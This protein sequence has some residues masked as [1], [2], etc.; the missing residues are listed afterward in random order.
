MK[1]S[2]SRNSLGLKVQK[3]VPT[4]TSLLVM[5][6]GALV[7]VGWITDTTALKSIMPYW[8]TMKANTAIC[9]FLAGLSLWLRRRENSP[10]SR[11]LAGLIC[12]GIVTLIS[13]LTLAE[14]VGQANFGIDQWLI[15]AAP[16]HAGKSQ[17]GRM[18]CATALGFFLI[19]QAVLFLDWKPPGGRHFSAAL[20][21]LAGMIGLLPFAGYLYGVE[22]LYDFAPFASMAM[23]TALCLMSLASGILC[24]RVGRGPFQVLTSEG[25][26]GGLS[27]RLMPV[28]IGV[29]ILIG[30]FQLLGE[31]AGF[32]RSE[33]GLALF[34]ISNV[35]T[36]SILIWLT[37]IWLNRTDAVVRESERRYRELIESLPQLVWTCNANGLCDYLGPQWVAYTGVPEAGQLG[38]GWLE[39]IHPNDRERTITSW[40]ATAGIGL[41]LDIEYRLRRNDGAYR[42]FKVQ[43]KALRDAAGRLV[44]WFGTNT[45]IEDL[46]EAELAVRE[47]KSLAQLAMEATQLG[48]WKW[49]LR[50]NRVHWDPQMF[51]LYGFQTTTDGTVDYTDWRQAVVP[52]D[53]AVQEKILQ[54]TIRQ[55]GRS[56]REF[57]IR[58]QSDGEVRILQAVE[59]IHPNQTGEAEW[60]VGTNL[61]VTERRRVEEA[62]RSSERM[63][64]A[65]G[66]S[67]DYGVWICAPDGRNTYTSES[68]LKL[69]GITQEECSDFGWG[70]I[71][72]PDDA[73]HTIA[74]WKECVRT[75]GVWDIEH[76][77]R[78]AEG[79][80]HPIL[81]RGVPVRDEDGKVTHW[82]GINLDIS[83]QKLVEE[84]L[85][86]S[87]QEV[88]NLRA[89]LDEH[90]I[91]AITDA[92]G[93]I[94]FVN[95]K[96]CAISQ[97]TREEL[98]G[99]DHRII[100]SG[101]HP[102]GF[103]RELWSTI[104]QGRV[105]HGEIKNRAKDGSFYWVATTIVPFLDEQG[106]P[107]EYVAI[108]AD[109][110][111]RKQAE[112][113]AIWLV[114]QLGE[115]ALRES[116]ARYRNTLDS[117]MEGCQIIGHDWRY[118]YINE[119]AA[120]HGRRPAT[121]F[122]GRTLMEI[123]PGVE[124]TP[125]FA[126]IRRCLEE[127]RTEHLETTIPYPDGTNA[128]FQLSIQPVPEGV[129][130]L[131]LD[132]TER[133]QAAE[134]LRTGMEEFRMLAE[135]MPQ[136]VWSTRAD[137]WN[138]YFNQHWMDYTGLTLE[139]S[140]GH[141]WNKPF[142]PDDQQ[143]A[144][145]A[146]RDATT[147]FS[148]YSLECRLRRADGVYR[149]WLIRGVP[150][151]DADGH[152]IKWIGT[153]TDI[154]DLKLAEAQLRES[155]ERFRGAFENSAIGMALVNLEG[156]FI[157][158]NR[159]LCGIVG[160]TAEE[161]LACTF[162]E[163]THP[164]DLDADL[165]QNRA[166]RAG[167]IDHYQ[168]EKRYFHKDG[169]IVWIILAGTVVR[170]AEGEPL[171]FVAQI[172]DITARH[173][174]EQR[175]HASLEEKVVLLREIHH[176]VKNNLQVITSLLQLQAGY[177][178]DPRDAEIFK[179]CQ[180]RIHAM[181]L[182]HDRLYRSGNLVTIDF[183]E[184]LRDLTA[185][186]IRGQAN[187]REQIRLVIESDSV[188]V[189]L[190]TAI[191]LGLITTELITNAYKHAFHDRSD[192][193]I[194][195]RL[196]RGTEQRCTL[197][198]EDDGVG[199]P[200]GFDPQKAGSL[201]L[202]LIRALAGQLRA[203]LSIAP[204]GAGCRVSLN[205]NYLRRSK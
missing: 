31:R 171:H 136:I 3:L 70:D 172:K 181:G 85:R 73:E 114:R 27:R 105:W 165:A 147:K 150:R 52:E 103:I 34:A 119:V 161:L 17:P 75:E 50:S 145:D 6:A 40:K 59:V 154:H 99:Q 127:R 143:R 60:L 83:K 125:L 188:E 149:W 102:K 12:A 173:E 175:L 8:V 160:R 19:S 82:A 170:D 139:E 36:F 111:E 90:A 138:N 186:I 13:L 194:T 131:S 10:K 122:L 51:S 198:V 130:V 110:T 88:G 24:A 185:L 140:L 192:G 113:R 4:I 97:Y 48:I 80:W 38:Y 152:I 129:F 204:S 109:V 61:D 157:R 77:F 58:R 66:E 148:I 35:L 76:R 168:M 47:N 86:E 74:A 155:E 43:A 95:D 120:R 71:L 169:H 68:C 18:S 55:R 1:K 81:A 153:C 193:V 22:S 121:E 124:L 159:A 26:G 63:Y 53:L 49:N 201:G 57:R 177:L 11:Q 89:A 2:P 158:V 91:V 142:H 78:G 164:D 64:R 32:F 69:L 56:T 23:H 115:E 30:W 117:M 96:F 179:E 37:A 189:N 106:K 180:A 151:R 118:L 167:E 184:H 92:R 123:S 39:Q 146:W 107:R 112:E 116:E 187:A 98:L 135:A 162:Q 108:R 195:V 15:I 191:P 200:A 5:F 128:A 133:K 100:N 65:I 203:E 134:A 183:S 144:W 197:S 176:R 132:I 29:P 54:E 93:R 156:R 101:F 137:G 163:I 21:L 104:A 202:R 196:A 190:D 84:K 94:T 41:P 174:A 67:I 25:L 141:G 20:G 182:I 16:D 72:H 87:L 79:K 46:R 126:A 7:L 42:W 205:F 14:Y 33:M 44:K 62:L 178:H 166:L 9:F 45:D 28:A 199:L